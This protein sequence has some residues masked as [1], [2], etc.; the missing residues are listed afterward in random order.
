MLPSFRLIAATFLCGFV[1]VF[2]GL[3]LAASLNDMHEGLPVMASHAAP[4]SAAPVADREARRSV[5]AVPVM[6][7]LRFAV[8]PVAPTLIRLPPTVRDLPAPPLATVPS[9]DVTR[10]SATEPA[11][12]AEPEATVSAI[13]PQAPVAQESPDVLDTPAELPAPKAPAIAAIDS[14][15]TPGTADGWP[16]AGT[17]APAA[18]AAAIEPRATPAPGAEEPLAIAEPAA[19]APLDPMAGTTPR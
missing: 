7:D 5:A 17:P 3:R 1:V 2:A 11:M 6:Y 16:A 15:A 12:Q 19:E 8:S 14:Q 13:A 4:A 10:E 9:E 18:Q